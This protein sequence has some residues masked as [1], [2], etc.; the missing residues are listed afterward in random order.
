[1]TP[2]FALS[3][4]FDGIALLQRV[5]DG[6]YPV[7]EVPLDAPDL[8]AALGR[9]REAALARAPGG[10]R[11]KLVIPADQIRF[12]SLADDTATLADVEAA[13]EGKTPYTLDELAVDFEV[14]GGRTHVAAVAQETL[15]EA[16]AF[17]VEHAFNPVA[18]VA[19]PEP[20]TFAGEVFFGTTRAAGVTQ[21]DRDDRPVTFGGA[22]GKAAA[23][24]PSDAPVQ[25]AAVSAPVVDQPVAAPEGP[26]AVQNGVTFASRNR[27]GAGAATAGS[28]PDGATVTAP[29]VAGTAGVWAASIGAAAPRDGVIAETAV[30]HAAPPASTTP[31][32]APSGPSATRGPVA[33]KAAPRG[34]PVP[35]PAPEPL[36]SHRKTQP[37][38]AATGGPARAG[39]SPGDIP[40]TP[41]APHAASN[42]PVV[43]AP[44]TFTAGAATAKAGTAERMPTPPR[45]APAT[46][47][48]P[49]RGAA[50]ATGSPG[51]PVSAPVSAVAAAAGALP[52]IAQF[53]QAA[54][55]AT[56]RAIQ[57]RAAKP[58]TAT[59]PDQRDDAAAATA[60]TAGARGKPRFLGLIMTGI[61][62]LVLL[63]VGLWASTLPAGGVAAWWRGDDPA[64]ATASETTQ[65]DPVSV[66]VTTPPPGAAAAAEPVTAVDTDMPVAVADDTA[67]TTAI[68][69]TTGQVLT[70]DEADRIY[71]ATGV[72]Q[73]AP[74]IAVMPR[75]AALGDVAPVA[76]VPPPATAEQPAPLAMALAT[77]DAVIPPQ[78]VPPAPTDTFVRDARG[79][80]AATPEGTVT[81][82]GVVVIAGS[83]DLRPV[84]RP[85]GATVADS[86][87]A[88]PPIA[89]VA[90]P[91]A[92]A[93]GGVTVTTPPAATDTTAPGDVTVIAGPPPLR[94]VLRPAAAEEAALPP[95]PPPAAFADV[96][97][98]LR[99]AGLAPPAAAVAIA[100][101]TGSRPVLRP[102]GLAPDA[103]PAD[104]AI[105]DA[106]A[107]AAAEAEAP[108]ADI[109]AVA[110]AI[111]AAAP[112]RSSFVNRTALAV[113][114]A[115]RP[116]TRPR[117]FAQVVA[118]AQEAAAPPPAA[119][120]AAP[121]S[122]PAATPV[123]A[124][125]V[126]PSGP[127]PGGVAQAA[128]RNDAM[129]LR[130]MNLVGVYGK[131]NQRRALIRLGNGRYVK[132]EIGSA[133]DGGQVTAIGDNAL[134]FV[135]RGRTYAL[136]LPG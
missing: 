77:P 114:V 97:P 1:M 53:A 124:T 38:V 41:A 52:R 111:A 13:L 88:A 81:P 58:R 108:A 66:A 87:S 20:G 123:A 6:W 56:T 59:T 50:R 55:A 23:D 40:P 9:L 101:Y 99:P 117:N 34:T 51:A 74:R 91:A 120:A 98:V 45:A 96:R 67:T 37:P 132:V 46:G 54:R 2:N 100:A 102:A 69:T 104:P 128:T 19:V 7:G 72:Y 76:S 109:N 127:V 31:N 60:T 122:A 92:L 130:Q 113:S 125:T 36:F 75:S 85:Q 95:A 48:S 16:E 32:D 82:Q 17:A 61:L 15:D 10:L 30:P 115:R 103:V 136:V 126:A 25:A 79:N 63:L 71:A 133:L 22:S 4:S 94:P 49:R 14:T 5:P 68:P 8:G 26:D 70:P 47:P 3:L 135:K 24:V 33:S 89:P 42:G 131:P 78:A 83:P 28:A 12:M 80:I 112:E 21:V 134:N 105:E 65:P 121:A 86:T 39:M 90:R 110:A 119:A 64:V 84:A 43:R 116:D 107:A 106:V 62:L 129:N 29:A 118:R 73:R 93:A 18:F 11:T 35:P 44:S 27:T 57:D